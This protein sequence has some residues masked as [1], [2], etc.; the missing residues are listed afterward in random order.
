MLRREAPAETRTAADTDF[1]ASTNQLQQNL[2]NPTRFRFGQVSD[3]EIS[4]IHL[5][6]FFERA[7]LHREIQPGIHNRTPPTPSER[8]VSLVHLGLLTSQCV[9]SSQSSSH[10]KSGYRCVDKP[11]Q[12]SKRSQD[13]GRCGRQSAGIQ[14]NVFGLSIC[15][16]RAGWIMNHPGGTPFLIRPMGRLWRLLAGLLGGNDIYGLPS[17]V[18]CFRSSFLDRFICCQLRTQVIGEMVE[19][20]WYSLIFALCHLSIFRRLLEPPSLECPN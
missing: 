20:F 17:I 6:D 18:A 8:L 10:P 7:P 9:Q 5:L 16:S 13:I 15:A 4:V 3:S 19:L 11:L 2:S 1:G 12:S 14:P